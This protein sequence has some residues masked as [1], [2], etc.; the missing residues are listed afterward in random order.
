MSKA[1]Y[2]GIDGVARKIKKMYIG[3]DGVARKVKK[4]YIGVNGVAR[5]CY[6]SGPTSYSGAHTISQ[7][8]IGGTAYNL[9][10][11]TGSGVLE[12]CENARYW[13][14]GGGGSG[15][16]GY[17]SESYVYAGGGG[18]GGYVSAGDI[19]AG[20]YT[21]VIGAGGN[22]AS[23]TEI[24]D[25]KANVLYSAD[26]GGI[27]ANS[28]GGD[29]GSGGGAAGDYYGTNFHNGYTGKGKG[30]STYPFG[31]TELYAHS[32]GGGGGSRQ[33]EISSSGRCD[34]GG[35]GGSNG[36]DGYNVTNLDGYYRSD[37]G[38][39]GG[40]KGGST[41]ALNGTNAT[42]Y[43]SG[44]GGGAASYLDGNAKN[45]SGGSGYQGVCYIL[46]PEEG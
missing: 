30:V 35:D 25:T 8:K 26:H 34:R 38:G 22:Q 23:A 37:G 4:A 7:V 33:R 29:G 18:G 16:S 41:N 6:S 43:G 19:P 17:A 28:S 46:I 45:G 11:L 12:L 42:F 1:A 27:S 5:L 32:A 36:S 20:T 21:V 14:V 2:I 44:G 10:T 31:L 13:M 9:Y 40:G 24:I 15:A 39:K 3:V